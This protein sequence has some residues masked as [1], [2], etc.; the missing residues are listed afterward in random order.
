MANQQES[1]SMRLFSSLFGSLSDI[2]SSNSVS[3]LSSL[4]RADSILI[5]KRNGVAPKSRDSYSNANDDPQ[6]NATFSTLHASP[7]SP[8]TS[9][10]FLQQMVEEDM[11]EQEG[12]SSGKAASQPK[13][14]RS[15]TDSM[16]MH[17]V[18]TKVHDGP[19]RRL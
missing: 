1:S 6:A 8:V 14:Q 19:P 5:A 3:S 13:H 9:N 16:L 12:E 4:F 15:K 17:R 10:P 7:T 2:T 18:E 11:Q